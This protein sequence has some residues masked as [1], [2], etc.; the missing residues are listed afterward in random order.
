MEERHPEKHVVS[1]QKCSILFT[2]IAEQKYMVLSG[3]LGGS[4]YVRE[5]LE[6]SLR[7][8]QSDAVAHDLRV[9]VSEDP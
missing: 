4:P 8:N 3:G 5:K 7:S 2:L 1:P 6:A 9:V